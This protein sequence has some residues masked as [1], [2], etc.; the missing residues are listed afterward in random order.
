ML[1]FIKGKLNFRGYFLMS[2]HSTENSQN[3]TITVA[4]PSAIGLFGLAMV[5]LV[6]SS[7]KLGITSDLSYVL[8]VAI[9][10]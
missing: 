4:D 5:T 3:V 7:Q 1:M 10:L 8:P 6:A 9:F 2:V